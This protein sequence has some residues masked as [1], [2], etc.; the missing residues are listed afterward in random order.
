LKATSQVVVVVT[1]QRRCGGGDAAAK[2]VC[3]ARGQPRGQRARRAESSCVRDRDTGRG[4]ATQHCRDQSL[5]HTRRGRLTP[6]RE[7]FSFTNTLSDVNLYSGATPCDS[8]IYEA[9]STLDPDC[10]CRSQDTSNNSQA[11]NTR[12]YRILP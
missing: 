12:R 5:R 2:P 6:Y 11:V 7:F 4:I 1:R 9:D 8:R 3:A 10:T